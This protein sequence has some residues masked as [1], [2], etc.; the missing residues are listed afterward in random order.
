MGHAFGMY[1]NQFRYRRT[2][3]SIRGFVVVNRLNSPRL[4]KAR[5]SLAYKKENQTFEF[6]SFFMSENEG[7]SRISLI[8]N[9]IRPIFHIIL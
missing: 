7:E 9:T 5:R 3:L 8:I 1:A 4:H 2:L 6:G